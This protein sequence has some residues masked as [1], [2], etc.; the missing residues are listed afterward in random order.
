MH[1]A[2]SERR[3]E[4]AAALR[5]RR[6]RLA[7]LLERLEGMLRATHSSPRLVLAR[8]PAKERF[9]AFWIVRGRV[10]DWGPL[11][12]PTELHNRT[13][14]ALERAAPGRPGVVPP[15][16]VDEVR[17]VSTWIAANEPP[18]LELSEQPTAS[19]LAGWVES[20]SRDQG[21]GTRDSR[22]R[23]FR[24]PRTRSSSGSRRRTAS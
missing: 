16:E 6:D 7:W 4:R 12:G 21:L 3:Y 24:P 1:A 20:S 13:S 22:P 23:P 8:H 19:E 2:A 11:P 5:R 15:E 9:D 10:A 17:I 14:A 18:T